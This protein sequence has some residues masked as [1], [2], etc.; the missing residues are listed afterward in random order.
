M[1]IKTTYDGDTE[2]EPM[3]KDKLKSELSKIKIT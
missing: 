3:T 1:F 2:N